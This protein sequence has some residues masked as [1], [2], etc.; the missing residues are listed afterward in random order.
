MNN[1]NDCNGTTVVKHALKVG[2]PSRENVLIFKSN[3][4]R[5]IWLNE[6]KVCIAI[7][8]IIK[9]KRDVPWHYVRQSKRTLTKISRYLF[10][11]M[12][13]CLL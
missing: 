4:E 9:N 10:I 5:E 8:T 6:F 13:V 2:P 1:N 12:I 3:D 11:F 7:M